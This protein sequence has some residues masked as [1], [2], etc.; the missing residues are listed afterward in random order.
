MKKL[1]C[2]LLLTLILAACKKDSPEPGTGLLTSCYVEY[3]FFRDDISFTDWQTM[4]YPPG[5]ALSLSCGYVYSNDAVARVNGGI[6]PVLF[7]IIFTK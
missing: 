1:I 4:S 3:L 6:V 2:L 5:S 7:Q